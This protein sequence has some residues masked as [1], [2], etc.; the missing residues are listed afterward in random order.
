MLKI[1]NTNT[2][3]K[4]M[5][6]VLKATLREL[7][8]AHFANFGQFRENFFR[9][10]SKIDQFAKINSREVSTFPSFAK[11]NSVLKFA[12]NAVFLA[13]LDHQIL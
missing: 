7:I 11:N 2:L 10:K 13:I 3:E 12:K 4:L 8:F 5:K 1:S 6:Y 9:E